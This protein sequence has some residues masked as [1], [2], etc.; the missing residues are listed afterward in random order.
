MDFLIHW[1]PG[2][3]VATVQ[4]QDRSTVGSKNPSRISTKMCETLIQCVA[5]LQSHQ[6]YT[7]TC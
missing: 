4:C 3:V 1:P 2:P 7:S 6:M 5:M